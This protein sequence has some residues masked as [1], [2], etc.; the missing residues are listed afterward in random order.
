MAEWTC[1]VTP[2]DG[3]ED[4]PTATISQTV[5]DEDGDGVADE[6]DCAPEL[7]DVPRL[8]LWESIETLAMDSD[9]PA[10]GSTWC[11]GA[12]GGQGV[13]EAYERTT[14]VQESDWN[15]LWVPDSIDDEVDTYAVDVDLYL[16]S[17]NRSGEFGINRTLGSSSHPGACN[18]SSGGLVLGYSQ[19]RCG[20]AGPCLSVGGVGGPYYSTDARDDVFDRWVN[21]RFEVFRSD[22]LVQL[23]IDDE[24][25]TCFFADDAALYGSKVK[26]NA[27]TSC[28]S[29]SPSF[30]ISNLNFSLGE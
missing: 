7:A 29:E 16:P 21:M 23:W 12:W 3:E 28:C 18:H 15:S 9:P 20:G 17:G 25:E 6:E 4:G 5:G 8:V 27:N 13:R 26:F 14:W 1:T 11:D 2:N 22:G 19:G 30:G 10:E 24:L